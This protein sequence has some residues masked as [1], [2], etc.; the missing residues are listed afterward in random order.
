MLFYG[1]AVDLLFFWMMTVKNLQY[2]PPPL[3]LPYNITAISFHFSL[4][5]F[6][7]SSFPFPLFLFPLSLSPFPFPL[8]LPPSLFLS[9]QISTPHN[10]NNYQI[11]RF[12]LIIWGYVRIDYVL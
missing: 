4:L 12:K 1:T 7:F 9:I 2:C 5:F 10:E 3:A 8:S 11:D 6:P